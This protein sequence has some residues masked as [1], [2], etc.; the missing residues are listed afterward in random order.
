MEEEIT[1]IKNYIGNE[2]NYKE[3]VNPEF[4]SYLRILS[5]R[6]R[7]Y[8]AAII[9]PRER[10]PTNITSVTNYY[11]KLEKLKN[12][13]YNF[14]RIYERDYMKLEYLEQFKELPYPNVTFDELFPENAMYP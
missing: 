6:L 12:M 7:N 5:V 1:R 10:Y 3:G 9:L 8:T 11:V 2:F 14:R 13:W 4:V